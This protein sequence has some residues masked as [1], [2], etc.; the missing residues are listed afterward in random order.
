MFFSIFLPLALSG[1]GGSSASTLTQ[2]LALAT[3]LVNWLVTT[4]A[5]YLTFITSN[6]LIMTP[7]IIV[8]A[9]LGVGMLLRLWGSIR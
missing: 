9:G 3:E 5:S 1:G 6:P 8:I 4:M 7:F 2:I